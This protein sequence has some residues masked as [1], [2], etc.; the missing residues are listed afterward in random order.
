MTKRIEIKPNDQS[1]S[2]WRPV[3]GHEE[4]YEVSSYGQIRRTKNSS[5]TCIGKVLKQEITNN[6]YLRVRLSSNG[7]SLRA[8]VHRL[9]LRAFM[10]PPLGKV[11]NHKDGNKLN[12]HIENL[13]YVTHQENMH[14]AVKLGLRRPFSGDLHYSSKLS[15]KKAEE[16]RKDYQSIKSQRKLAK[17]YQVSQPLIN[18]VVKNKSWPALDGNGNPIQYLVEVTNV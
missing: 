16:I 11:V 12:N 6:G 3:V 2:I 14:H 4:T 17:I 15:F 13:E 1:F 8:L 5:G 9:V 18:A 10:G 7:I